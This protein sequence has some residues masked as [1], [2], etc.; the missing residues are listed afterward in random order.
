MAYKDAPNS[1][2]FHY[3]LGVIDDGM[4]ARKT[5]TLYAYAQAANGTWYLAGEDTIT[6]LDNSGTK[7]DYGFRSVEITTEEPYNIGDEIR[8]VANVKNYKIS[9]GPDYK[10]EVRDR[11]GTLLNRDYENAL[12]GKDTHNAYLYP[13]LEQDQVEDGYIEYTLHIKADEPGWLEADN[14]DNKETI[15]IKIQNGSSTNYNLEIEK[16]LY[17]Y[18]D[19][20]E[21]YA[22]L[23]NNMV[24]GYDRR[25]KFKVIVKNS[26]DSASPDYTVVVY[27][28]NGSKLDEDSEPYLDP[29]DQTNAYLYVTMDKRGTQ[30]LKFV[31]EPADKSEDKNPG[32][33]VVYKTINFDNMGGGYDC[34][35]LGT[36]SYLNV[37]ASLENSSSGA[38]GALNWM[39][40][41]LKT[42]NSD[43][44]LAEFK[45]S[46]YFNNF[47]KKFN[48]LV[49]NSNLVYKLLLPGGTKTLI[50]TN[51]FEEIHY[52]RNLLNRVPESLDRLV[53]EKENWEMLPYTKASFHMN[54]DNG[55]FNLKFV[56]KNSQHHE[57]IYD[58]NGRL[59]TSA[60]N[61][62]TYNYVGPD[63]ADGHIMYDVETYYKWGNT[64]DI[65]GKGST[66]ELA[67]AG[68]NIIKFMKNELSK[69]HYISYGEKFGLPHIDDTEEI[70]HVNPW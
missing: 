13:V 48:E 27:D 11:D 28:E 56:S 34:T 54:G 19:E 36:A 57:A 67:V 10:V 43:G 35:Y 32:D 21:S 52:A 1:G 9:A 58:K 59:V 51:E 12:D 17:K 38:K 68:Y 4:S 70:P 65:E 23:E 41:D 31:V 18:T 63:D 60:L 37:V 15:R 5:Y 22:D 6:T 24:L 50:I 53:A 62:G 44:H 29:K 8:I 26:T 64:A 25:I 30:R 14:S 49:L 69:N 16:I 47:C 66:A 33:N 2:T 39:L 7:Y 40:N 20:S 42:C 45:E 55:E 46:R 61:M 3:V